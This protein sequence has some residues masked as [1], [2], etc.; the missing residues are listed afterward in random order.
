[1]YRT[2][3]LLLLAVALLPA[4][5]SPRGAADP[6]RAEQAFFDRLHQ[7]CGQSFTG[8]ST[9][10]TD[11]S[12]PLWGVTLTMHVASCSEE[13]VRIR[14]YANGD[15]SRTWVVTSTSEGLLLK[16]DH[17][18]ADG[19]PED[20]TMYGG[21]ADGKGTGQR[22]HFPADEETAGMLPEARTNVWTLEF[23]DEAGL[24]I[25]NLERNEAPRF[26]AEFPLRP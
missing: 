16:H 23:D 6:R 26:R 19:T 17:R 13:Q 9:F 7:Y 18:H 20:L 3:L 8:H 11:E 12:G 24:F 2:L 25:Y 15:S 4:A 14:L 10:T 21:W 5:C 1:M 22:Q